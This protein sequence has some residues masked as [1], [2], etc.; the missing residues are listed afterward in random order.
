M[1]EARGQSA[2][3][4]DTMPDLPGYRIERQLGRGSMGVVYLAEDIQLRRK[5]ALKVLTPNLADDELFRKRFDRES[6]SAAKLDHPNIVPVYAAGEAAGSLYIA[7]RYVSGG[8]L[9]ELIEANGPLSLA[10][11]TSVIAAVADA[12][13]AAHAQGLVHRDVKPANILFDGRHGQ[14]HYYLSDFGITKVAAG[15]TNL[16]STGQIVGTIDYI[17]PEQIHGKLVD[18]RADL[19]ALGCVLY[20]CLTGEVPFPHE[21][22]AALMWAHVH[23]EPPP[24]T[25][26][27][28]ELPPQID[29]IV[30]KAMAKQP[31]NRYT[32]CREL[33]LALRDVTTAPPASYGNRPTRPDTRPPL[34]PV[35]SSMTSTYTP[36]VTP[37]ARVPVTTAA[38]GRKWW[39]WAAWGVAALVLIGGSTAGVR[40]YLHARSVTAAQQRAAAELATAERTLIE[41]VPL[42]ARRG[43]V[44]NADAERD[45]ANVLAAVTCPSDG[46]TN[47][48]V[49]TKFISPQARDNHYNA[50]VATAVANADVAQNSGHCRSDE[51]AEGEYVSRSGRI[52]GRAF[53]HQLG[54]ASVIEWA[55]EGSPILGVATWA[56]PDHT[57]LATWWANVVD[58]ALPTPKPTPAPVAQAPPA[59]APVA[60]GEST[61]PTKIKF[62]S[63]L[64]GGRCL[65][66]NK[67]GKAYIATC[68]IQNYQKWEVIDNEIIRHVQTGSCLDGSEEGNLRITRCNGGD[69]QKWEPVNAIKNKQTGHCLSRGPGDKVTTGSCSD[70]DP[71]KWK[72]VPT[73]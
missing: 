36:L 22:I 12:L 73:Q 30:A 15:S 61:G 8:D 69:L 49:F 18:G 41:Q 33:A 19:Y 45:T 10:Q 23:D 17:P 9:R 31:E 46:G 35:P 66:G 7:M 24:A 11:A 26:R 43:C 39:W 6:Q 29:G 52:R 37:P 70:A 63:D 2:H 4:S 67:E 59:R 54:G 20:H 42:L 53:C 65:S 62:F 40:Y 38:P 44:P 71:Q 34:P 48:I 64:P 56:D 27:R 13:D 16:T 47:Q 50:D 32:T 21:E 72:S 51:K 60:P 68:D 25:T 58:V 14:E 5:V 55:E 1:A 57:K 3:S 28:P